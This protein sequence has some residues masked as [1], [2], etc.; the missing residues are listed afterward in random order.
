[1]KLFCFLGWH[2]WSKWFPDIDAKWDSRYCKCGKR[3]RRRAI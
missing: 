3:Q 2:R 1:M